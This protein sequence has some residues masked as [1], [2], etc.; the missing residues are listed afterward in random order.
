MYDIFFLGNTGNEW[1]TLKR[2]YPNVQRLEKNTKFA[3]ICRRS[4]TKLFWL[5]WDDI[6][7]DS[8]FNF[9]EYRATQWD[10]A[11][12]HV[13]KNGNYYDGVCLIPKNA[14]VSQREFDNRFFVNNKKEID[15]VASNPKV[16][17]IFYINEYSEYIS[18]KE[19][20]TT[21]M[22]WIVWKDVEVNPEFK[23][24]YQVPAYD[25]HIPHIFKNGNFFDGIC[26]FPTTT[27]ITK[28]EFDNR[29]FV[30]SKKEIDISASTPIPYNIFYINSYDEYLNA[31]KHSNTDM[32]WVVWKDVEILPEFK[33]DYKVPKYEQHIPHVFKNGE[34]FDGICIFSKFH[35]VTKK[36]FDNRFFVNNKKEINVVASNPKPFDIIFISY[37]ETN[38]DNNYST[39]LKKFPRTKRVHGV[40]GIHQAHIEAAKLCDTEMLWV[41]DADATIVDD[42]D[43][44]V[45]HIPYYSKNAR[46]MLTNT[47]HV[48]RSR[49]PVNNLE[50]G[51]G[52][53]KLL[54]KELTL[55]MNVD[56]ADMTTSISKLFKAMPEVSNIT[57]FNTDP[58]STWRSAFRECVKLSSKIIDGQDDTETQSRL[59]AWCTVGDDL[60][61]ITGAK[62]GREYGS[63][64]KDNIE[65]LKKINDFIWLKE[66]FDASK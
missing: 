12:I 32:F 16:F 51:Y 9:N 24:D 62:A 46:H 33:F 10:N 37:N 31:K 53:V 28:K 55:N 25:Q 57:A 66:Q 17:D 14:N 47:V 4:F 48:W 40:K 1:D 54:P 6:I 60:N 58:F 13:F 52:G 2:K 65:A 29:F 44:S 30:N 22:F 38:A 56:S 64:N 23:F 35:D 45:E 63:A 59:D 5:V 50:Y 36:E 27:T 3:D 39:I 18:A 19:Q 61:A 26:I 8:T 34:Y 20:S 41:V 15:I 42:F 43:F 49:N 11:Y 21:N 7:L